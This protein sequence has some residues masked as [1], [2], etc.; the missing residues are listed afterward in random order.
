MRGSDWPLWSERIH[1]R[2]QRIEQ[3]WYQRLKEDR[4][5]SHTLCT[6]VIQGS[7]FKIILLDFINKLLKLQN[8]NTSAGLS[9]GR[10]FWGQETETLP[11]CCHGLTL[12]THLDYICASSA[13]APGGV[14]W[15]NPRRAVSATSQ[16]PELWDRAELWQV[17]RAASHPGN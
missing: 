2:S 10:T 15:Q 4:E 12:H 5:F 8:G 6:S 14:A 16:H 17:N 9:N 11:F 7:V 1:Q 13:P 3:C